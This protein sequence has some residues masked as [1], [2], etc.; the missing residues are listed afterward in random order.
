MAALL[1][2]AAAIVGCALMALRAS[3]LLNVTVWL[4]ATSVL[5]SILLYILDAREA[6]V[7]ELSVGAGLATVLLVITITMT[8]D[9]LSPRATLVPRGIA[10][11]LIVT[12]ILLVFLLVPPR[13]LSEAPDSDAS[14]AVAVWQQRTADTLLQLALVFTG[15]LTVL[16]LL[17][18]R[19]ALAQETAGEAD[20]AAEDE[21][22][23]NQP[24]MDVEPTV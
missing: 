1:G 9:E 4:V 14:F 8:G 20:T 5:T 2:L 16:G 19:P 13:T 7:I 10:F 24:N 12:V 23:R 11:L 6:A 21:A 18:E 17:A 15:L 3:R 22:E